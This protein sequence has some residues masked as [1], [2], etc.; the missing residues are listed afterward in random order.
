MKDMIGQTV[1]IGSKAYAQVGVQCLS[2]K[3]I[4]ISPPAYE[5][6]V[7]VKPLD[8]GESFYIDPCYI[9]QRI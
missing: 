3:V 5:G 7:E 9:Q 8:A 6:H 1:K 4:K 2:V